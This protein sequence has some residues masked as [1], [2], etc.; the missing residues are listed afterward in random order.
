MAGILKQSAQCGHSHDYDF[1]D[2]RRVVSYLQ[3]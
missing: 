2:F 3:D 1:V